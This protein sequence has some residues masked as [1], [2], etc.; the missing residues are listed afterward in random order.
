MSRMR[1]LSCFLLEGRTEK[2]RDEWAVCVDEFSNEMSGGGR[3]RQ[4]CALHTGS[5]PGKVRQRRVKD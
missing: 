5:P 1:R 3:W 4:S 2:V